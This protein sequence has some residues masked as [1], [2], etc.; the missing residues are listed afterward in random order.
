MR[1]PTTKSTLTLKWSYPVYTPPEV[2]STGTVAKPTRHALSA[3]EALAY[4]AGDDARPLLVLRE[5]LICNG[6]DDALLSRGVDNE[7]T[8][9]LSRWF[10]CVKLPPDVTNPDHPFHSL[11]DSPDPEH[12][13]VAAYDGSERAPLESDTSRTELWSAMTAVLT[14]QYKKDPSV[15]LKQIAQVLDKLDILDLHMSDLNSRQNALLETEGP[16][17]KK[18][19]KVRTDIEETRKELN[20]LLAQIT[21]ASDL[22]LKVA[23]PLGSPTAKAG[24]AQ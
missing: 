9:L 5:C 3:K 15:S 10:H 8:L 17:S 22:K 20:D 11:F 4:I 24:S 23:Q 12:L 21:K 19:A 18:L 2:K 13:F 16:G 1:G 14:S 7:K 6:T